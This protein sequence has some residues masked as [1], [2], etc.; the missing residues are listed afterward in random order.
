M[1]KATPIVGVGILLLGVAS[2]EGADY[3]EQPVTSGEPVIGTVQSALSSS[4]APTYCA[5]GGP[6]PGGCAC[7]ISCL[8]FGTCCADFV[9][10]CLF[11]PAPSC[12]GYCGGLSADLSCACD[13]ACKQRGDCCSDYGPQCTNDSCLLAQV[14]TQAPFTTTL[15][16]TSATTDTTDPKLSCSN[17]SFPQQDKNT[18]WFKF[19]PKHAGTAVIDATGTSYQADIAVHTGSCGSFKEVACGFMLTSS[20][21]RSL[22]FEAKANTTYYIEAT[23]WYGDSGVGGTLKLRLDYF[24]SSFRPAPVGFAAFDSIAVDPKND[25]LWYI[26]STDGVYITVDGGNSWAKALAGTTTWGISFDPARQGLV[27]VGSNNTLYGTG[28][29]GRSFTPAQFFPSG[30][31][32]YSLLVN[33]KEE[34]YV[35]NYWGFDVTDKPG[36]YK[37]PGLATAYTLKPFNIPAIPGGQDK[38]LIIWD[39][40]QDPQNG[41]LYV[42]A[43]PASKPSNVTYDPPTLRSKDGGN[44]WQDI[45]GK[46]GASGSLP[47]HATK[48]QVGKNGKVYFQLEGSNVYTS[49]D[50]G[51]TSQKQGLSGAWDLILDPNHSGVMYSSDVNGGAL[52][53]SSDDAAHFR[54]IGPPALGGGGTSHLAFNGAGTK[55]FAA[56][57]GGARIGVYVIDIGDT[58]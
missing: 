57:S 51:D 34:I 42:A 19:T 25:N 16:T 43:E 38:G 15:T 12:A 21:D 40:E 37:A 53:M 27:F 48:I 47:W 36:L 4:C 17:N 13:T 28:N 5:T 35:G 52:E 56:R 9:D 49:V 39:I 31:T 55:L 41:Y 1:A 32:I 29:T 58:F 18:V 44:T 30:L 22:H 46:I 11:P 24:R 50:H 3:A 45:S 23:H 7:D 2:C 33:A 14:I 20:A 54:P 26:G 8:V 10:L 6:S